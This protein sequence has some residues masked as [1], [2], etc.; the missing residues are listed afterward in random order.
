MLFKSYY[1]F[2]IPIK[3]LLAKLLTLLVIFPYMVIKYILTALPQKV[4]VLGSF[5]QREIFFAR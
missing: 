5:G 4:F 1:S 3:A 2:S